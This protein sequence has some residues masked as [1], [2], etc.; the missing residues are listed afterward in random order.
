MGNAEYMGLDIDCSKHFDSSKK[1]LAKT[2]EAKYL[3]LE[4]QI[5][6]K[7]KKSPLE[8]FD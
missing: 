2:F 6:R 7:E 4:G 3:P 5:S 1:L 8:H